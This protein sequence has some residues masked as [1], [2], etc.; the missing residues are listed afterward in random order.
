MGFALFG[1]VVEGLS[2]VDALYSGYG[3]GAPRGSGPNQACAQAE[4]NDY[5]R[6]EFPKL[7]HIETA[8]L[9]ETSEKSPS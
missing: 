8:R 2:V 3:E 9:E 5:F 1:R 7:D 6:R 4:G